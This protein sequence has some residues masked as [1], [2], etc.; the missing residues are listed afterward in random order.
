MLRVAKMGPGGHHYY[1]AVVPEE[2][3]GVEAPGRWTGTLA[4]AAGL[5]GPVDGERLGAFLAGVEPTSGRPLSPHHRRVRVA[6]FDLTVSAPKSVSLLQALG[7]PDVAAEVAAGHRAAVDAAADY[8]ERRAVAVRRHVDGHRI[9]V[10][11]D[12]VIG[13][14]FDHRLTRAGDPHLHTHLVLANLSRDP[15]GWSALDGR[16]LYAHRAAADALYHAALRAELTRRLGVDWQAPR[17]GRADLAGVDRA[18]V[19]GFSR[20]SAAIAEAL[21]RRG[22]GGRRAREVAS[23]AT[24]AARDPTVGADALRGEWRRRA[25][26][27]GFGP[28]QVAG[29]V[30]RAERRV[31]VAPSASAVAAALDGAGPLTRRDV[32]RMVAS[33]SPAGAGREAVETVADAVLGVSGPE[34]PGV[35]ERT[36]RLD[37]PERPVSSWRVAAARA[38]RERLAVSLAARGLEPPGPDLG[39]N[40]GFD[41]G[42]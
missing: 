8:V 28:R 26:E 16:G 14:S 19:L 40:G 30:D 15:D 21:A 24:R 3:T 36:R 32:V 25:L 29:V 12:G 27:L 1:L 7:D 35:A 39:R 23:R 4:D 34:P 33:G 41:L 13:A 9:P 17:H 6:A 37:G 31:P 20:R 10:P 11:A 5:A 22:G 18:T 2:G 42:R 38:E